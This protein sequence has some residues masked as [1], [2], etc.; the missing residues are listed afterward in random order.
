MQRIKSRGKKRRGKKKL[1]VFSA[2][3][4]SNRYNETWREGEGEQKTICRTNC[5]C[6][7]VLRVFRK[8]LSI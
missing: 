8:K 3:G 5:V 4:E 2:G 1:R 6:A 7:F